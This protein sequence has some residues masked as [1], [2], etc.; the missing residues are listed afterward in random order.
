MLIWREESV[1]V[2]MD[3]CVEGVCGRGCG[4]VFTHGY[5]QRR[6]YDAERK[7]REDTTGVD[8]GGVGMQYPVMADTTSGKARGRVYREKGAESVSGFHH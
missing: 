6:R 3:G 2:C 1:C 4:K 5:S 7:E 8:S